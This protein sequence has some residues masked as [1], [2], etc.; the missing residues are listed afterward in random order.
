MN[1]QVSVFSL[2]YGQ[3]LIEEAHQL[4][5]PTPEE[6]YPQD[7]N[8][9]LWHLTNYTD[10][11]VWGGAVGY[12]HTAQAL[13]SLCQKEPALSSLGEG[14][15][16]EI[17]FFHFCM[18]DQV[19]LENDKTITDPIKRTLLFLQAPWRERPP[20]IDD[21]V[22]SLP[23]RLQNLF[24]GKIAS[25]CA[26]HALLQQRPYLNGWIQERFFAS[27]PWHPFAYGGSMPLQEGPFYF[28]HPYEKM[29]SLTNPSILVFSS[30]A[31]LVQTVR[32]W[33]EVKDPRHFLYVLEIYPESQWRPDISFSPALSPS[34]VP[35]FA[36]WQEVFLSLCKTP[37]RD[38]FDRLYLLSKRLSF[39][40]KT[41]RYGISRA[42][43]HSIQTGL[44]D[45]HDPHRPKKAI[46]TGIG[47]TP[48]NPITPLLEEAAKRRCKRSFAPQERIRI[49][50]IV[51]QIVDGGHAP[52]KLLRTLATLANRDWFT[53]FIISTER[54][55]PRPLSY[56][57]LSYQSPP[58]QERA[59]NTLEQFASLSIPTCIPPPCSTYEESLAHILSLIE[60]LR[61]DIAVFHGPDELHTLLA[62]ETAVPLRILF[63]HGTLPSFGCFELALLST[64]E[65]F[66]HSQSTLLKLGMESTP[67][68]FCTDPKET[69]EPSPFSRSQLGLPE[70][71]FI[72][73][74]ISNHLDHRLSDE[75]CMAIGEILQRCPQAIYAPIGTVKQEARF[76]KKW[77]SYGVNHRIVFLGHSHHPSQLARSMHL[78]LNEFPFGSGLSILDAM[79]A[80]C[81]VVS[82]YDPA[83]PQQAKYGGVY[84]GK[85]RVIS[86]LQRADY[87]D[88]ACQLIN[89]PDLYRQWSGYAKEE[90]EKRTDTKTYVAHFEHILSHAIEHFCGHNRK[91]EPK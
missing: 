77:E 85:T 51:S 17:R 87:V 81:P 18:Q 44:I 12:S 35:Y 26:L 14:L 62:A 40:Q 47:P 74:T 31:E 52:T 84:F 33:P 32:I 45:W 73:T 10:A 38:D 29:P 49:A 72:L 23:A 59:K 41:E 39:T 25:A 11:A 46:T 24:E 90:C 16:E 78:Y 66:I 53:P 88:L 54:F 6:I 30:L 86:S 4:L 80:G 7:A 8:Q 43:P 56:P 28:V 82:M 75:M 91:S 21:F 65:S 60:Q 15:E 71:A 20:D 22:R 13:R 58:S 76:R 36:A 63:D 2:L 55:C 5:S 83:G 64:E 70:D 27:N 57:V 67:L 48:L 37:C 69:W 1:H 79:A 42:I 3:G 50:H 9:I 19:V 89:T 61:I 68:L 34:T